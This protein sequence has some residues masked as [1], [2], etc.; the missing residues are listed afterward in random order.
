MLTGTTLVRKNWFKGLLF[1]SL[2]LG[3]EQTTVMER[4]SMQCST[5]GESEPF[6]DVLVE[7]Q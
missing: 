1:K 4:K 6:R 2:A 7:L 3:V 5:N